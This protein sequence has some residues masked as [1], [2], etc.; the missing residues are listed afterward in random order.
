MKNFSILF[1]YSLVFHA[2]QQFCNISLNVQSL[3]D[4]KKLQRYLSGLGAIK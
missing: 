3:I 2:I 1:V 4:L